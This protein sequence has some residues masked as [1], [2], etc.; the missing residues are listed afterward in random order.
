MHA[1]A[2]GHI[3]E[4]IKPHFASFILHTKVEFFYH[5]TVIFIHL[6]AELLKFRG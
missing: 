5:F 6:R 2:R 3:D 1:C 4:I